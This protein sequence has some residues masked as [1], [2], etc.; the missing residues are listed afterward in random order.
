MGTSNYKS[1]AIFHGTVT[2]KGAQ[3]FEGAVNLGGD[4]TLSG[5]ADLKIGSQTETPFSVAVTAASGT[6]DTGL[7]SIRSCVFQLRAPGVDAGDSWVTG[8][9]ASGAHVK[10]H[11][12]Q[13]DGALPTLQTSGTVI[14]IG[15]R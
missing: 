9:T 11:S 6:V 8:C 5:S 14:V 10:Y 1:D 2:I 7:T 15:T 13:N 4:L 12:L 3:V